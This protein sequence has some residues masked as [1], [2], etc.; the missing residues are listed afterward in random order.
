MR[1]QSKSPRTRT[2]SSSSVIKSRKEQVSSHFI[3]M[4]TDKC[5]CVI[6]SNSYSAGLEAEVV[7]L[8][9]ENSR[10][11]VEC[12]RLKEDNRKLVQDQSQF[13]DHTTKMTEELKGKLSNHL[14]S[15]LLP[16]V[17]WHSIA[18]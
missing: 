8:R 6:G 14:C 5:C 7:H 10:A 18:S 3:T 9:E 16:T 1:R 15:F 2:W 13:W 11:V 4:N 12:D 17:V